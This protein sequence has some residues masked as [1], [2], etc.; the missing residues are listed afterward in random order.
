MHYDVIIVGAGI[1]GQVIRAE[2]TRL[3]L[4]PIVLDPREHPDCPFGPGSAASGN[5][6]KPSWFAGLGKE[7]HEPALETLSRLY[8]VQEVT[9]RL[10]PTGLTAKVLWIPPERV[11]EWDHVTRARVT[12]V[13]PGR[14]ELEDGR[15]FLARWVVVAAGVWSQLLLPDLKLSSR[16]GASFRAQGQLEEAFVLPWAPYKQ[17]VGFNCSPTEFWVGD[18]TALVPT[19]LTEERLKKSIQRCGAAVGWPTTKL[20]TTVGA[21][22]YAPKAPK[23]GILERRDKGLVVATGG[24]KNGLILAGHA[25]WRV[26]QWLS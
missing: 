13:E 10:R 15:E 18:G 25:A 26:G 7:I 11:L 21:R 22:P 23:E 17:V 9:A 24:A 20:R 12:K 6:M 1:Y 16:V 14:V 3:G 19:S 4:R 2:L 5:L 8:P